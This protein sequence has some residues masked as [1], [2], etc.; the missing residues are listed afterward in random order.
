MDTRLSNTA[1][2]PL[3][4]MKF[5]GTSVGD[6]TRIR[7]VIEIIRE[8]A[9]ASELV[10]VVSAMCGV[11]NRLIEA[12][13]LAEAGN[14]D[15]VAAIFDELRDR[16]S[17]VVSSLIDSIPVRCRVHRE[18][19]QIFEQGERLSQG[20]TLLRELTV[21][22][23]DSISSLGERLSAHLVAA[24]LAECG[25]RSAAIE[26]TEL[27]VTDSCH[28]AADPLMDLTRQRCEAHLR[29]LLQQDVIPVVTGFIGA[30]VDG[31]LTTLG[32]G[33]S[34]YSATIVGAALNA[35][36]V[37]IWTDV[38]GLMTADP[39]LVPGAAMIPE[40][41]YR[42]AAELAHFGAK[43]LHPKTISAVTPCGI[44][45][46]I[47]NT[48]S[49]EL[50]GT[51]VT[52]TGPAMNGSTINRGVKGLTAL[53]DVAL[54]TVSGP[55]IVGLPDV[56]DRMFAT[57]ESVQA[58]VLLLSQSSSQNDIRLVVSSSVAERTVE[59]LRREFAQ[60]L[61][62]EKVEHITLDQS[63]A[64]VTLVGKNMRGSEI[65]DRTF[66][67]LGRENVHVVAIAQDSSEYS[68]SFV[69]SKPDVKPALEITH[70]EFQLGTPKSLAMPVRSVSV[71]PA[72][73]QYESEQ[74][75]ASAD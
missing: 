74:R 19:R 7:K 37:I 65:V 22:A 18:L 44:P 24:A 26:A 17:A 72:A 73:W 53:S 4:I 43:V 66:I 71:A 60:D 59:A 35:D 68:I 36:E 61:A 30:T 57:T 67:A 41:S 28:G 69:V 27:V 56:L 58:K 5:G 54:I 55:G 39:R 51:R 11:T 31:K 47:R 12:A 23:Q 38:D 29:P 75:T 8:A 34:D 42:E 1:Q 16:H 64:I 20:A 6:A 25:V 15:A 2:K 70:R 50:P 32:R 45:L 9:R 52:P 33:G 62:H 49:P 63:I 40:I 21:R 46:W 10:V 14:G 3:R 13:R 48:F